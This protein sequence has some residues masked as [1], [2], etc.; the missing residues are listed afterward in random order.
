MVLSFEFM[1]VLEHAVRLTYC[2]HHCTN[3]VHIPNVVRVDVVALKLVFAG[4]F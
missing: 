2:L 4:N 3:V 1:H